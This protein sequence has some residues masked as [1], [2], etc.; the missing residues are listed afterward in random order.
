MANH[1]NFDTIFIKIIR[2]R[3]HYFEMEI[4]EQSSGWRKTNKPKRKEP[5]H[6]RSTTTIMAIFP[7]I[8]LFVSEQ[9]K[10]LGALKYVK[11]V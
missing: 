6:R 5:Y 4:S 1:A 2:T 11:L 9:T 8:P 3:I 7:D 10:Y